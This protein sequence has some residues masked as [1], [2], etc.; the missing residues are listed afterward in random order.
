MGGHRF[1]YTWAS[2]FHLPAAHPGVFYVRANMLSSSI[3]TD[4]LLEASDSAVHV[5]S[6]DG[7]TI[8]TGTTLRGIALVAQATDG[9][10]IHQSV[11]QW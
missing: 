4:Y 6:V 5:R 7:M 8:S 11:R 2:S 1:P 3:S 10:S 9:R